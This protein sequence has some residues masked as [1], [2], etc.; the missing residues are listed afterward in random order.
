LLI[1]LNNAF[2]LFEESRIKT[3]IQDFA[4]ISDNNL[5]SLNNGDSLVNIK[6]LLNCNFSINLSEYMC[7]D[8]STF[9][10]SFE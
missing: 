5:F 3:D 4:P 8:F 9:F 1:P 2:G 7:N 10:S 6:E